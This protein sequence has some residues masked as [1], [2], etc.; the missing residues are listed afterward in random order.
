MAITD[1]PEMAHGSIRFSI[2]RENTKEEIDYT[3]EVLEK[4][5]A[6]LRKISPLK[7]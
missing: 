2:G 7:S 4:E 5:I 1:D 3:L 6:F